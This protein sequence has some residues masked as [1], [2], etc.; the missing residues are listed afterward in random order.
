MASLITNTPTPS[1]TDRL[2]TSLLHEQKELQGENEQT[3]CTLDTTVKSQSECVQAMADKIALL[4][5]ELV[6]LKHEAQESRRAYQAQTSFIR[7]QQAIVGELREKNSSL[8]ESDQAFKELLALVKALEDDMPNALLRCADELRMSGF[9]EHH[10]PSI[11]ADIKNGRTACSSIDG[12]HFKPVVKKLREL[13]A[14]QA[15]DKG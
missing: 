2:L 15:K 10:I 14:A 3:L 4:E 8:S 6:A 9:D 1:L 11:M 12:G 13:L 7:E 5:A